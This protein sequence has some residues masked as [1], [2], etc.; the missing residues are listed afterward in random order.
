M[1]R[2]PR[3]RPGVR[4]TALLQIIA[5]DQITGIQGCQPLGGGSYQ[6][7]MILPSASVTNKSRWL[8]SL[9]L[10][11]AKTGWPRAAVPLL[12]WIGAANL[13][14]VPTSAHDL[15]VGVSH[16]QIKMVGV[17]GAP[18]RSNRLTECAALPSLIWTQG[19]QPFG[20]V[21]TRCS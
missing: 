14:G 20:G 3:A 9:R 21:P 7:L 1:P 19:C 6:V 2:P 4:V 11:T 10:Q 8:G 12:I 15:A 17:V 5:S 13:W 18:D 16:E